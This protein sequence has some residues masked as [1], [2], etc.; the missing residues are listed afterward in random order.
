M[1]GVRPALLP[2]QRHQPGDGVAGEGGQNL[3]GVLLPLRIPLDQQT[4]RVPRDQPVAVGGLHIPF[5]GG[6]EHEGVSCDEV[7]VLQLLLGD[8]LRWMV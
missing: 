3:H 1:I 6:V 7:L 8:G 4:G 2:G 5:G